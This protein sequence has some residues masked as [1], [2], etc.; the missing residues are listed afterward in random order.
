MRLS[1]FI[2]LIFSLLVNAIALETVI[3]DYSEENYD[4]PVVYEY[5]ADGCSCV[6]EGY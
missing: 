5:V 2:F 3:M 4:E 1:F 6:C